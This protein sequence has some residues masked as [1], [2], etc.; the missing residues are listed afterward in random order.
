MQA[1]H[2]T[3]WN[4]VSLEMID[5]F[6]TDA[7]SML[8]DPTRHPLSSVWDR[9]TGGFEAMLQGVLGVTASLWGAPQTTIS[10][11]F[12]TPFPEFGTFS[13]IH[14]SL[15]DILRQHEFVSPRS[16][17]HP[18]PSFQELKTLHEK[19]R[20]L[21]PLRCVVLVRRDVSETWN[22]WVDN[23]AE[24]GRA[25]LLFAT[26]TMKVR[27]CQPTQARE[28]WQFVKTLPGGEYDGTNTLAASPGGGGG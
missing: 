23:W 7:T 25:H 13:T 21:L 22:A 6:S 19:L 20:S 14:S 3:T 5:A 9:F 16:D 18:S 26:Q 8:H 15:T 2:C 28:Q 17:H 4:Q 27:C 24:K 1:H 12:H 11:A 10:A